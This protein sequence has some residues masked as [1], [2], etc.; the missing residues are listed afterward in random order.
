MDSAQD[1]IARPTLSE[2][3]LQRQFR[4]TV[5]EARA[6]G[7]TSLHD[8]GFNPDSL[9]FFGRWVFCTVI[10][11]YAPYLIFFCCLCRQAKTLPVRMR[12]WFCFCFCCVGFDLIPLFRYFIDPHLRNDVLR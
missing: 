2:D 12:F 8:A 4:T 6:V 3:D 7:L 10:H 11:G 1:L 5:D 9:A